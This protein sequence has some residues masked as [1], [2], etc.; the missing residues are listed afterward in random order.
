MATRRPSSGAKRPGKNAAS[1]KAPAKRSPSKPGPKKL[2]R[3]AGARKA[4]QSVKPPTKKASDRPGARKKATGK[5]GPSNRRTFEKK[6][7]KVTFASGQQAIVRR[8]TKRRGPLKVLYLLER[9]ARIRKT[10]P[11]HRDA[12]RVTKARFQ[13]HFNRRLRQALRTARR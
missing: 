8:T 5:T 2:G 10:F 11:F 4:A 12:E 1:R 6:A 9:R 7:F 13:R 3:R